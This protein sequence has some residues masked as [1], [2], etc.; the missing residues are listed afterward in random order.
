MSEEIEDLIFIKECKKKEIEKIIEK[1]EQTEDN[2][3]RLKIQT[4]HWYG[5]SEPFLAK[6]NHKLEIEKSTLLIILEEVI[7]HYTEIERKLIGILIDNE[8]EDRKKKKEIK[9]E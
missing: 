3:I 6:E 1:V 9:D 4:H 5:F 8:V 7:K 2:N